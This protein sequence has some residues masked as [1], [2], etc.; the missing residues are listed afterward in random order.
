MKVQ[1]VTTET[2]LNDAFTIRK[3]V[4][5]DEQNVPPHIERDEYDQTATHVIGYK[6]H[7][8]IATGRI[9]LIDDY[10]KLERIAVLKEHRGKSYGTQVIAHMEQIILQKGFTQAKLNAQTHATDFYEKL[11]YQVI[12]TEFM[13]AGIPHVTMKKD[14]SK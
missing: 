7:Q 11:G 12:S 9:R 10:G 13:D 2:E 4:F 14:L 3:V 8:P 6:N 5:I 1:M